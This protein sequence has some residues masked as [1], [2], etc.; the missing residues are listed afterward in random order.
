MS[1]KKIY[2][3]LIE[4][5][6]SK[7]SSQMYYK[8]IFQNSNLDWKTVYML[9]RIVTKDSRLVVFQYKIF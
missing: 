7:P 4:L 6:D 2:T 9:P 8:N 3:I 1:S 5:T